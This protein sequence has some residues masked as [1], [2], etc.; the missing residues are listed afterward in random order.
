MIIEQYQLPCLS[1]S[2][3]LVGD[4]KSGKAVVIDPQRDIGQ[5]LADA[6]DRGLTIE[7]VLLTHFHADYVS[8][9]LGLAQA[10]G[11]EIVFG[12]G[13]K[14]EFE[15]RNLADRERI[16]LG[17]VAIEAWHTPGHTPEST[18]YL[19]FENAD[20]EAPH[21]IFTGD[22]LF[23]ND[24]GRPDLLG[25]I[26][27]TAEQ[28]GSMLYDSL[29]RLKTLPDDVI[30]YPG[31]GAGS[32]CGKALGSDPH[33]TIGAQKRDNYALKPMTKEQFV[34]IVTEGQPAAPAYFLH[35]AITN[36]KVHDVFDE[37]QSIP[38]M[39]LEE[40]HRRAAEGEFVIID[41]R[42]PLEF[43]VG[44]VRGA[45]NV[46]LDGRYAEQA[47]MVVSA[48]QDIVVV[49]D[50][51]SHIEAMIRLGRIGFDRV[52]GHV[53]YYEQSML[54][55]PSLVAEAPRMVVNDVAGLDLD[56]IQLLDVRNPGE[57]AEGIIPGAQLIPLA[58]LP[59]RA[60]DELDSGRPVVVYCAS[61]QR[62]SVASS[63]LR[64]NGFADV[65]DVI[66]GYNGWSALTPA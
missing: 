53:S 25:A 38:E 3:Y 7:H 42:S 19:V 65:T 2:S 1:I 35:D 48:D 14:T 29:N 11:A 27:F 51:G 24:V 45:V 17:D 62:S 60:A 64:L 39:P 32:A 5:Y 55:H 16:V 63:W 59:A 22:T 66:G 40:A 23:V 18:T 54:S 26:G 6:E 58:Q 41:T 33:T 56:A 49:G 50:D 28:L 46:P 43:A 21:A 34:D 47:G 9:H 61:G 13:A 31:H 15:I 30:V 52:V 8:G 44:H 57:T 20:D 10:T 12:E 36:R 4:E 37:S